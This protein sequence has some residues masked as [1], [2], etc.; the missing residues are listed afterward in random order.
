MIISKFRRNNLAIL[1]SIFD[2]IAKIGPY[3]QNTMFIDAFR[4]KFVT[5]YV[6]PNKH[7]LKMITDY[8]NPLNRLIDIRRRQSQISN[9]LLLRLIEQCSNEIRPDDNDL[10]RHSFIDP[11]RDTCTYVILFDDCFAKL[12]I[13]DET[14]K[15]I[16]KHLVD[17]GKINS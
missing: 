16:G 10:F 11:A 13:R 8:Y 17:M 3:I 9:H 2:I 14:L 1:D 7:V 6:N 15:S 4:D 5:D 12:P